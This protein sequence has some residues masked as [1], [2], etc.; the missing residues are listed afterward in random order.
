MLRRSPLSLFGWLAL[1]AALGSAALAVVA[2]RL[3]QVGGGACP[4]AEAVTL[5]SGLAGQLCEVLSETQPATSEDWLVVRL[6]VPDLAPRVPEAV[7]VDHD[8]ACARF[9]LAT[10]AEGAETP[11]RIVVQLM[12]EAFP[13]GEPA[14][15]ITQS[16]EAYSIRD[17]ACIWELF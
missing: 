11:A 7:P 9:G 14:P 3:P 5:P 10:L 12:A 17:G 1:G 15:G 8:W 2:L 13:R 16:I 6:V 4:Q